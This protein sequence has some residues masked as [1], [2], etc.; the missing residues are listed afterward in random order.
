M[1]SSECLDLGRGVWAK[2]ERLKLCIENWLKQRKCIKY[3][4]ERRVTI[5]KLFECR[6]WEHGY[7]FQGQEDEKLQMKN[8]LR[9]NEEIDDVQNNGSREEADY[10]RGS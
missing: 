3:P 4:G 6:T 5:V 10:R 2:G 7:F 1:N 9:D 8:G